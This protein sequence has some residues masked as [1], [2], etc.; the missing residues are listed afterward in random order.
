MFPPNL[1]RLQLLH[2]RLNQPTP[3]SL[4]IKKK[5]RKKRSRTV[6]FLGNGV[7]SSTRQYPFV[8]DLAVRRGH[9]RQSMHAPNE[10]HHRIIFLGPRARTHWSKDRHYITSISSA[11]PCQ[12]RVSIFKSLSFSVSCLPTA[13]PRRS[14]EL[15][16]TAP[17]YR[18]ARP[19]P[20]LVTCHLPSSHAAGTGTP[21]KKETHR[22]LLVA[23]RLDSSSAFTASPPSLAVPICVPS[24]HS[25]SGRLVG[26]PVQTWSTFLFQHNPDPSL[27]V[28]SSR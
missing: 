20:S 16:A 9:S 23:G 18:T 26:I 17:L 5:E 11:F 15:L 4:T 28:Q 12:A 2:D 8:S 6:P 14:L 1:S 7:I 24:S 13:S 10:F 27:V 22:I 3:P 21:P 19:R 25:Q